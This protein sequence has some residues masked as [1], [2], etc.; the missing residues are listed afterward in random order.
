MPIALRLQREEIK[1]VLMPYQV[2]AVTIARKEDFWFIVY[3]SD[4][5]GYLIV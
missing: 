1:V 3:R 4:K 2:A 5:N